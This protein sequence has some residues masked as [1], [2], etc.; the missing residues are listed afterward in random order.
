MS[1][2][3]Q[4]SSKSSEMTIAGPN[5]GPRTLAD[6]DEVAREGLRPARFVKAIVQL[7]EPRLEVAREE[8]MGLVGDAD[9]REQAPFGAGVDCAD[10]PHRLLDLGGRRELA[11]R[12]LAIEECT[13]ARLTK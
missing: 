3:P 5:L 7:L 2:S 13:L 11:V 12:I 1:R 10:P 9:R 4:R 8:G 6:G